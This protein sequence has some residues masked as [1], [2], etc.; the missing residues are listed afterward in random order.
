[1]GEKIN[2]L[3][4][5][6]QIIC[7]T[8]LPQI[9]SKGKNHFLVKKGIKEG[10]TQTIISELDRDERVHEIAR[11]MGGRKV[12]DQAIAHAKEMLSVT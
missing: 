8:H 12:T 6:H 1:V 9:A 2:E 7:I 3:S 5:F 10:R 11:L 4:Q